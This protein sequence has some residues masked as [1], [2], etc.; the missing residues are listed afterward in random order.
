MKLKRSPRSRMRE[1]APLSYEDEMEEES[2]EAFC[3]Q[4]LTLLPASPFRSP[5][6]AKLSAQRTRSTEFEG[7]RTASHNVD[8]LPP[9]EFRLFGLGGKKKKSEEVPPAPAPEITKP[10]SAPVASSFSPGAGLVEEEVIEGE[11]YDTPHHHHKTDEHDLDDYEEE[12]KLHTQIRSGELGEMLQEAHLDHRIQMKFEDKNGEEGEDTE[13][14]EED[15]EEGATAAGTQPAGSGQAPQRHDRGG[16]GRRGRG[17]R[18]GSQWTSARWARAVAALGADLGFADH[19]RPAE[20]RPGNPGADC[21][22]AHRQEGC[23]HH[24]PHCAAGTVPGVH[25]DGHAR[26]RQPQDRVG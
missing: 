8:P 24:Q 12:E 3:Q 18:G 23:P 13:G 1:P 21:E 22:G 15:E 9:A 7:D 5:R 2:F 6:Q 16:R 25:A 20:A 26:G 4:N 17:D 14:E 19:F 11:E 10:A